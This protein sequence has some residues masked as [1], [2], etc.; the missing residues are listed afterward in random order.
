M[1]CTLDIPDAAAGALSGERAGDGWESDARRGDDHGRRGRR[2]EVAPPP[3]DAVAGMR[4]PAGDPDMTA[5]KDDLVRPTSLTVPKE[6]TWPRTQ[7]QFDV[8]ER[9]AKFLAPLDTQM[10]ILLRTKQGSNPWMH[11]LEPNHRLNPFYRHVKRLIAAGDYSPRARNAST[12]TASEQDTGGKGQAKPT[13]HDA[14][15]KEDAGAR[16]GLLVRARSSRALV[17]YD[18]DEGGSDESVCDRDTGVAEGAILKTADMTATG[19]PTADRPASRQTESHVDVQAEDVKEVNRVD[20]TV[21]ASTREATEGTARSMA[22]IEDA[23]EVAAGG[24]VSIENAGEGAASGPASIGDADE[25]NGGAAA[26]IGDVAKGTGRSTASPTGHSLCSSQ[27]DVEGD[28]NL[29]VDLDHAAIATLLSDDRAGERGGSSPPAEASGEIGNRQE[30]DTNP[31]TSDEAES[32]LCIAGGPPVGEAAARDNVESV[33][34]GANPASTP[35]ASLATPPSSPPPTA[36]EALGATPP[37]PPASLGL[38]PPPPALSAASAA[39]PSLQG[40]GPVPPQTAFGS[41]WSHH[42]SALPTWRGRAP[43]DAVVVPPP[44]IKSIVD[45]IAQ[46]VARN[47]KVGLRHGG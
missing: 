35:P 18:S 45:K 47:G 2:A 24:P 33:L 43:R 28:G 17:A 34:G 9:T 39:L 42:Y 46:Y 16:D 27:P 11:F 36:P 23:G 14:G 37:V 31:A 5:G 3:E 44:D 10:E 40:V 4:A 1:P 8:L 20:K 13:Q 25:G 26:S 15:G 6:M 29:E 38:P 32:R 30:R 21:D 12:S 19:L 41:A 22:S 7:R